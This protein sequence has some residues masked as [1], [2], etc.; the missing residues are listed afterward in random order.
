MLKSFKY[1]PN[2]INVYS[3][4]KLRP[5]FFFCTSTLLT[6]FIVILVCFAIR[7][8]KSIQHVAQCIMHDIWSYQRQHS[9]FLGKLICNLAHKT[10]AQSYR[11][12]HP[13]GQSHSSSGSS[14]ECN[15]QRP[16]FVW[17]PACHAYKHRVVAINLI[18]KLFNLTNAKNAR[19]AT[20]W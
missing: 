1:I 14:I 2:N 18:R 4:S 20:Q 19:W 10:Y 15:R 7:E 5:N 13:Y 3:T 17:Q 9:K 6:R 12:Q 16:P 11:I 8:L